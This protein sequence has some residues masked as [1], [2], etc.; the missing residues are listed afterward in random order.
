MS[1][2]IKAA[3][4]P[5]PSTGIE[6]GDLSHLGIVAHLSALLAHAEPHAS[7]RDLVASASHLVCRATPAQRA[8]AAAIY[9]GEVAAAE[10]RE[11][12]K[13]LR[14]A[15]AFIRSLDRGAP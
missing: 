5:V 15:A 8:S 11:H 6:R 13:A 2:D 4:D 14:A 9:E 3:A 12:A 7:V 1:D 10:N